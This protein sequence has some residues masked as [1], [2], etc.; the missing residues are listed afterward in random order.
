MK[1][2]PTF[3]FTEELPLVDVLVN[4]KIASS[5]REAREFIKNNAI[6]INGEVVNDETKVVTK[7]MALEGKV[8]IFRRGKK[9][10]FLAEV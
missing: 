1:G 5:K 7:D 9:K 6:S 8:I 10:Y 2:V 4:N 3:K